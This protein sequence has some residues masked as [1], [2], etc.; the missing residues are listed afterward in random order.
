MKRIIELKASEIYT[1]RSAAAYLSSV[2]QIEE[3]GR[4]MQAVYT[5]ICR[6]TDSIDIQISEENMQNILKSRYAYKVML[7]LSRASDENP[8]IQ[9]HFCL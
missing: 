7:M 3:T 9:I 8:R 2:F 1:P 5:G 6:Q 4:S